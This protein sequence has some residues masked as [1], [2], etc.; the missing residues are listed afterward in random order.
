MSEKPN[1]LVDLIRDRVPSARLPR[2]PNSPP[3]AVPPDGE[4]RVARAS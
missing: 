1:N 2:Y 3:P 4:R